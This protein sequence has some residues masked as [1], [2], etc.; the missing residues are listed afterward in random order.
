MKVI[1]SNEVAVANGKTEEERKRILDEILPKMLVAGFATVTV[2]SVVMAG[3][4][5][6]ML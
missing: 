2:G 1:L 4:M 6:N 5:V 3:I